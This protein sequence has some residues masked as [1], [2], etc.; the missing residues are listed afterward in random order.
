MIYDLPLQYA[1]RASLVCFPA[2]FAVPENITA[3]LAAGESL[4]VDFSLVPVNP[5][6]IQSP[7]VYLI[8]VRKNCPVLPGCLCREGCK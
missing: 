2:G 8:T 4:V 5:I 3:Q 6:N 7:W 1:V